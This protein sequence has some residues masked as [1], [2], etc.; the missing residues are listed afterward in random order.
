MVTLPTN[1]LDYFLVSYNC[2]IKNDYRIEMK[3]PNPLKTPSFL[4]KLQ[5]VTDPVGYMESAA[6]QHQDIFTAEI[7]GFGNTVV[8]V[9][10]PQAIQYV[11][12]NDR[13]KFKAVGILNG[14]LQP[15]LGKSSLVMIEGDRHRRR[16]QIIMPSFHG[17]RMLAY[18]QLICKIT[19]NVFSQLPIDKPISAHPLMQDI[20]LQIILEAILGV[21]KREC[22]DQL[23]HLIPK[24][25]LEIFSSPFTSSFLFFPFLQ[26]DVG[27]WSPWGRF[28]RLRQQVDELLYAEIA[29]RREKPDPERIDILSLLILAQD[30][31]GKSMTDQE[32][33]DE[34]MILILAGYETTATSIAWALYWIHQKPLIREK[35]LQELNSLGDS[36]DLMS[37]YKLP[38]LTAVCN[39]TLRIYPVVMFTL[40]RAVQEPLEILGHPLEAGTVVQ[41]CIYLTHQREDLYPQPKQF[42]PER[43]LEKQFSPYEFIPFGGGARGCIGQA[44]SMYEMKLVLAT[45]LSNYQLALA[46]NRLERPQRR[47][48]VLGPANGVKM[49]IQGRRKR[50]DLPFTIATTPAL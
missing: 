16:R 4:Q 47:G 15:L 12:T 40:P 18:G 39:E 11:L 21:S 43:F 30:E 35:I 42:K 46:D 45:I 27:S 31:E 9:D 17:E 44:L 10:H 26:R 32:L 2:Q 8:F 24:Y 50:H 49:L 29:A 22:S 6:Q 34:L 33:R 25:L 13:K 37:V 36:Q 28:V 38:Y 5:W 48:V 7:V 14:I 41:G 23:K 19:N 20:S 3:L 1:L